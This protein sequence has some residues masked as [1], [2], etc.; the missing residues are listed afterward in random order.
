MTNPEIKIQYARLLD[1]FF[2]SLFLLRQEKG[3]IDAT[4]TYPTPEEIIQKISSFTEA[5]QTRKN[6]LTYMQ[7][8][9]KLDFASPVI[10]VF[11]VGAMKGAISNPLLI[12]SK[13][14][15]IAF[16]DV[17]THEILHVLI[18]NNKQQLKNLFEFFTKFYPTESQLTRVHVII[19]AMMTKIYLNFLNTPEQLI[20]IKELDKNSPDYMRAWEIV[21]TEGMEVIL[22]KFQNHYSFKS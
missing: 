14:S 15:A 17:L 2:K 12:G 16:T 5:W 9:F 3:L 4:I 22:E 8:T 10:D 19:H 6:V 18:S 11:I 1:P 7:K 13:R 20:T 21:E